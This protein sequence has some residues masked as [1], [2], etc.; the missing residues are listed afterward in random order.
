MKDDIHLSSNIKKCI[1]PKKKRKRK[2]KKRITQSVEECFTQRVHLVQHKICTQ[3]HPQD[4]MLEL[5]ICPIKSNL[6]QVN[7]NTTR[8]NEP[9]KVIYCKRYNESCFGSSLN[10]EIEA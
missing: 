8:D 7:R 6:H 1:P 5:K 3:D 9:F 10:R 2:E 4:L